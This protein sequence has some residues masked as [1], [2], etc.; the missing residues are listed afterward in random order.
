M[1]DAGGRVAEI[2]N[3]RVSTG[4]GRLVEHVEVTTVTATVVFTISRVASQLA[5]MTEM[6]TAE[7]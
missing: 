5:R 3:C 1:T 7:T 6:K 2:G 4:N